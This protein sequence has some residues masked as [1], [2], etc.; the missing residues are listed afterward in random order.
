MFGH[1]LSHSKVKFWVMPAHIQQS[2]SN[3][4]L[5]FYRLA[6]RK[7]ESLTIVSTLAH[8]VLV[9]PVMARSFLQIEAY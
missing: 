1:F 9:Q 2:T 8:P 4:A 7:L 5:G 3:D 6:L